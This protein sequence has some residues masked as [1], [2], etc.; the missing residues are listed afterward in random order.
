MWNAEDEEEEEFQGVREFTLSGEPRK[1]II[2]GGNEE[3]EERGRGAPLL[4]LLFARK[5]SRWMRAFV[6]ILSQKKIQYMQ[7]YW[8][9]S[10]LR[11]VVRKMNQ[12]CILHLC[13]VF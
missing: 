11:H 2:L 5:K 9:N 13:Q 12:C 7:C 4:L 10:P 1:T 3:K 8:Y 6:P